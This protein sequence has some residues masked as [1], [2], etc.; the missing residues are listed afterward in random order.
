MQHCKTMCWFVVFYSTLSVANV[1]RTKLVLINCTN[2]IYFIVDGRWTNWTQWSVRRGLCGQGKQNRERFCT[3]PRP[4]NGERECYGNGR[5]TRRC[6]TGRRCVGLS[7]FFLLF[8]LVFL[9]TKRYFTMTVLI[10]FS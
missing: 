5:E 10:K 4:T 1:G 6:D 3:N 2:L 7:S 8:H 9:S